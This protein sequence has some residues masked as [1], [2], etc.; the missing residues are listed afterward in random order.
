[1]CEKINN[2]TIFREEN[3]KEMEKEEEGKKWKRK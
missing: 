2:K 1:M 3:I